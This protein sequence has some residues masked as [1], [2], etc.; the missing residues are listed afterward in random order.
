MF[1]LEA[2]LLSTFVRHSK[3]TV[4]GKSAHTVAD[5]DGPV[6]ALDLTLRNAL[7]GFTQC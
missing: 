2:T 7:R 3:S 6:N 5:G 1:Q 4:G